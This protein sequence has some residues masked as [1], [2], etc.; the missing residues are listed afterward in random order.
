MV[1][2][3]AADAEVLEPGGL[4]EEA[5]GAVKLHV[6]HAKVPHRLVPSVN[7]SVVV[8]MLGRWVDT[9]HILLLESV[10]AVWLERFIHKPPVVARSS[11][12]YLLGF[13]RE[14]GVRLF[15]RSDIDPLNGIVNP[16]N[17][18]Q[19]VRSDDLNAFVKCRVKVFA[20]L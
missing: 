16:R 5:H 18:S 12:F 20:I 19:V 2:R 13:L 8:Q 1:R 3:E 7:R 15:K 6:H 4:G 11:K 10:E 17:V 9:R 14:A